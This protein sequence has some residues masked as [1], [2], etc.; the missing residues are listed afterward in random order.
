MIPTKILNE[1][2]HVYEWPDGIIIKLEKLQEDRTGLKAKAKYF[3]TLPSKELRLLNSG[4]SNL[5]SSDTRTRQANKLNKKW[6]D[7]TADDWDERLMLVSEESDKHF[8]QGGTEVIDLS[9]VEP[10]LEASPSLLG[11]FI[12]KSGITLIYADSSAG[13]SMFVLAAALS[14]A[15]GLDLLGA[16]PEQTGNVL[17]LDYED[18]K[19]TLAERASALLAGQQVYEFPSD[20]FFYASMEK[21]IKHQEGFIRGKIR[22]HEI[23]LVVIDS[24]SLAAGDP[25]EV[26][27]V[28]SV[29]TACRRLRTPVVLIH[30]LSNEAVKEVKAKNK[31]PYGTTFSRAWARKLWLIE[32]ES[33]LSGPI[34]RLTNTKVN[35]GMEDPDLVFSLNITNNARHHMIEAHYSKR[36]LLDFAEARNDNQNQS[37]Y[38]SAE[39]A[40]TE[41]GE[42]MPTVRDE[43]SEYL[44]RAS[45]PKTC[46][47]ITDELNE[48]RG[49]DDI[50]SEEAVRVEVKRGEQ[51]DMFEVKHT[52]QINGKTL[53]FWG[54]REM[55]AVT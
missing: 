8:Y 38:E 53:K 25:T 16:T 43:I 13:K 51:K 37:E 21:A 52:E 33:T 44:Q 39:S 30:H 54:I 24:L 9:Q 7:V 42:T 14:V 15:T 32:K 48:W 5:D 27:N 34:I 17:Y 6:P 4:N 55:E 45:H 3:A 18:T 23:K 49:G 2:F 29:I 10:D 20:K 1:D 26:N 41:G 12:T 46:K 22:D 11:P 36:S 40:K 28:H 35:N 47:Q 50:L 31:R 19:D